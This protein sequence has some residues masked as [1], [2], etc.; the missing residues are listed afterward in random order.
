[1]LRMK[2]KTLAILG[3]DGS[4]KSTAVK[5]LKKVLGD[6]C[7][8][9]YMGYKDFE[10][11]RIEELKGKRWSTPF[12]VYRIYRC[13]WKR[14]LDAV[15]THKIAIFDRYIHEI[16]INADGRLKWVSIILYKF[17]FPKPQ[18]IVYLHCSVAESLNRKSDISDVEVF[19]KM[20]KRFD[21][22][23]I[24]RKQVLSLDTG[25]LSVDEITNKI[26]TFINN[27]FCL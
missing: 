25:E 4:G 8:I 18:K 24:N 26:I 19:T 5:N 16:F 13:F 14:Y 10:D 1:M 11:Q 27:S 9:T 20:K 12:I 23:F 7:I 17:F 15:R 3:V 22:Y 6:R 21:S 2:R